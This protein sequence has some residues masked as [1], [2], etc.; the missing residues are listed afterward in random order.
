MVYVIVVPLAW[1]IWHLVFRIRV[2]GRENLP[3]EGG[4]IIAP[5]HI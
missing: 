5:N 1:L 2:Y 3:R 4:F